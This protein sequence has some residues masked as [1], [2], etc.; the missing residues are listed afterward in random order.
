MKVLKWVGFALG[1]YVV[2]VILCESLVVYMGKRQ[3]EAGL[4]PGERWIVITTKDVA[5][6]HDTVVAGV[7]IDGELYVAAN[8]WPR[9]W[10]R[11]ALDSPDVDVTRSGIRAAFHAEAVEGADEVRVAARYA[12]PFVARLLTGFPPRSF[13]HLVPR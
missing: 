3:A 7:D 9:A 12:L 11:R 5:G 2:L 4:G 13:L 8:H 1:A 10:F 6:S